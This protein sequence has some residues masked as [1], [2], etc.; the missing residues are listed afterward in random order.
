MPHRIADRPDLETI[1]QRPQAGCMTG[2]PSVAKADQAG[3]ESHGEN[4]L[5]TK[6]ICRKIR[7]NGNSTAPADMVRADGGCAA[8]E[9]ISTPEA[10]A[11]CL[12][13]S[14][15]RKKQAGKYGGMRIL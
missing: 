6:R 11:S 14:L 10:S 4:G 15:P 8:T 2:L 12:P 9:I 3:T 5:S 13:T 1:A 7:P